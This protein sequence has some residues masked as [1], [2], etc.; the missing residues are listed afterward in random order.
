MFDGKFIEMFKVS[1]F[2]FSKYSL[3]I[4]S[5]LGLEVSIYMN[6]ERFKEIF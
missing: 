2:S 5:E 6:D 4:V 1:F 3:S